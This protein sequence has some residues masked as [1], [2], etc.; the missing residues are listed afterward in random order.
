MFDLEIDADFG[1]AGMPQHIVHCFFEDEEDLPPEVGP[2]LQVLFPGRRLEL[3]PD[4]SRRKNITGE[5]PHAMDE[6]A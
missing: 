3:K 2:H 6:V 4:V 1:S 5:S